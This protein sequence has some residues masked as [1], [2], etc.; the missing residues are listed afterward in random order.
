M[1]KME[2]VSQTLKTNKKKDLNKRQIMDVL[3]AAFQVMGKAIQKEKRFSY[4]RFG[5]F[6]LKKRKARIWTLPNTGKEVQIS[7]MNTVTF[8]PA[9]ALKRSLNSNGKIQSVHHEKRN[10]PEVFVSEMNSPY[11]F[12]K[13][14]HSS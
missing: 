3:D 11:L 8:K 7:A 4:S 6:M 14:L 1:N 2:F 13:R 10:T 9:A 5:S 12:S